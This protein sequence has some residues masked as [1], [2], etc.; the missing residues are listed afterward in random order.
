MSI[1]IIKHGNI[2]FYTATLIAPSDFFKMSSNIEY[3][4]PQEKVHFG[5]NVTY[6]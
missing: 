1:L 5:D 4:D 6:P 3:S 2:L